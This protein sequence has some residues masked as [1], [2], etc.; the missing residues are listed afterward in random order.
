MTP[1]RGDMA[2]DHTLS[3]PLGSSASLIGVHGLK[4]N[5]KARGDPLDCICRISRCGD[6]RFQAGCGD[7]RFRAATPE[8]ERRWVW[9]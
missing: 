6:D 4:C 2:T 7:Q 9:S 1:D 5:I 3:R 8:H